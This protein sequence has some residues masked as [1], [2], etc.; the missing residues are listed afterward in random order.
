[1]LLLQD[2]QLPVC[3]TCSYS[4]GSCEIV[5]LC[6]I[7]TVCHLLSSIYNAVQIEDVLCAFSGPLLVVT[8]FVAVTSNLRI[9]S[10]RFEFHPLLEHSALLGG[11]IHCVGSL[12][13]NM[14][15]FQ[16]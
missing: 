7:H 6:G 13:P 16:S 12:Y 15:S 5:E 14:H 3:L 2:F 11:I 4:Q 8:S 1:M 9:C 10:N